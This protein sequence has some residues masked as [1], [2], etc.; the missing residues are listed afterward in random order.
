MPD[1]GHC[2]P[3]PGVLSSTR[4]RTHHLRSAQP[5]RPRVG[6]RALQA[7]EQRRSSL[8][9]L[10]RSERQGRPGRTGRLH[11]RRDAAS[12]HGHLREPADRVGRRLR[13]DDHRP[14]RRRRSTTSTRSASGRSRSPTSSC[15]C[16]PGLKSFSTEVDLR[17]GANILVGIDAALDTG[18]GI[19]TWKFTTLDP[20]THE[21]PEDAVEDGFLPPNVTSPEGEGA[22]LFTVS[23]KPGF[24]LGTTVCNN[25]RIVFDFNAPIDT[26]ELLQHDRRARGLRRIASTTTATGRSTAPIPT[27]RAPNGGGAGVGD[28]TIGK[29]VDK[30]AKAIRKVGAKLASNRLKQLGAC[31]EGGRGLRAAE[32]GRRGVSHEGAGEVREGADGAAGRRGEAHGGHLEELRRARRWRRRISSRPTGLGFDG[33]TDACGDR[34]VGRGR[35]GRRRR[36]VRAPATRLRGRARARRR[37]AA[38]ARAARARR[39]RS[40]ARIS[41]ALRPPRT[42]AARRSPPRS[43]RHSASAT[44]RSRRRRPS[45]SPAARRPAKPAAPPSSA[46]SRRSPAIACVTKAGGACTKAV[47]ALPKLQASFASAIAKVV[48]REPLVPADL[49]GVRGSRRRGARRVVHASRIPEPRRRSPTSARV[50]NVSSRVARISCSRA[51]RRGS[52]SCSGSGA[53]RCPERPALTASPS[54]DRYARRDRIPPRGAS[55]ARTA[56][57]EHEGAVF[58]TASARQEARVRS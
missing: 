33:E 35:H 29:A 16:R 9:L 19:V 20:A 58:E 48:R 15:R 38:R 31:R 5:D 13:G 46:A 37:G 32:A 22:V 14:A 28:A 11:R 8:R 12:V 25:A 7:E 40:R 45:C 24:G 57:D 51:R 23:L 36:G 47:A 43:G 56:H 21:F 1:P 53:S 27:A 17:P 34:G 44:A 52:E 4:T 18:T 42:A 55:T 26:P 50:S 41:G 2:C 3:I 10:A 39:V 49:L 54:S 6:L 30:C